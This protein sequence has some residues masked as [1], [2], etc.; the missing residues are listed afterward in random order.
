M[1]EPSHIRADRPGGA[2][3][4]TWPDGRTDRLPFHT[5]RCACP[6]AVCVSELTGQRL[7][8]PANISQEIQPTAVELAGNYALK[9]RWS[10]GHD[11]GLF[12]WPHLR[13]LGNAP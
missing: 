6:C 4:I 3:E 1:Q 12:S 2:F 10:D 8:D 5:V 7:L 13:R 11:T 9:V